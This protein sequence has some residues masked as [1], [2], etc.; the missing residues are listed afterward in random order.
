MRTNIEID[1]QLMA[2]AQRI[3]GAPTKRATVDY[4]L[5][6][7]VRRKRRQTTLGLRGQVE[8]TGDLDA[9]RQGR[10]G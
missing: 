1:E 4:A 9:S 8:W 7:L 10:I 6:E 5:R 3:A 2:E